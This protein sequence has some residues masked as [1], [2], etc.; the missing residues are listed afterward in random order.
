M[1]CVGKMQSFSMS[2]QVVHVVNCFKLVIILDYL[3]LF[4]V[5]VTADLLQHQ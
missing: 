3:S 2:K 4:G 1:H 5:S